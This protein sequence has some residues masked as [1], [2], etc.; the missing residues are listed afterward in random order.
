MIMGKSTLEQS[1]ERE[2]KEDSLGYER[3][4]FFSDAV[5]AIAMTLL[6]I[7]IRLPDAITQINDQRLSSLLGSLW[8]KYLSYGIS[9]LVTGTL[10]VGHH[11]KF[12]YI[13][14]YDN[15]LMYINIFLLMVV[16]FLPFPTMVLSDHTGRISIIFYASMVT[17]EGLLMLI[18][19]AYVS[20]DHKLIDPSLQSNQI[21]R[22]FYRS[23]IVPG[24][25]GAS[26]ALTPFGNNL[27]M[28]FWILAAIL[29]ALI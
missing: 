28:F 19:W 17:V 15:R 22:E 26:I 14:R 1:S 12:R 5:F 11:R 8:P 6:A 20:K 24:V 4:V 2:N 29:S 25:F 18:L 16:A 13:H 23:L 21:K 3:L 10:W 7:D 27:P 9:F